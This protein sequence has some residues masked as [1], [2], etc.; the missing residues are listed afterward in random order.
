M[1]AIAQK[2][3]PY[4]TYILSDSA[5]ESSIDVVP[6]RGGIVTQWQIGSQALLYLDGDRFLDP[7]LS[8]RG[9]IPILF[10][11]CGNLPD[12]TYTHKGKTYKLP[13]HGFGRTLPWDVVD[14]STQDAASLTLQLTSN[15][16]TRAVYPFDFEITFTYRLLGNTLSIH[17]RY[18]NHSDEPMPFSTGLHPYFNTANAAN[19]E[20]EIPA[21]HYQPKDDPKI[22]PF[23]GS[24]DFSQ[25][26][27]DVAFTDVST[28]TASVKD[29]DRNLRIRLDYDTLYSTLVFWSVK[30]KPFYCLEPWSAPRNAMNSGDRLIRLDAGATLDTV[31]QISA[32]LG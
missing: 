17:Q 23:T 14:Q 12:D 24:F 19:L 21:S 22:Y 25:A 1:F 4:A 2:S 11:I 10:P 5:A 31:V 26:E 27:V 20:L 28:T 29:G 15:D 3:Q 32:T 8:I 16:H 7:T 30:G 9:G 6:G 18:T 13:Q